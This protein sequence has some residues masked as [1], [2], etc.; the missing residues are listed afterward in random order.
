MVT[1]GGTMQFEDGERRQRTKECRQ[2]LDAGKGKKTDF[3]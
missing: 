1:K 2:P 3:P